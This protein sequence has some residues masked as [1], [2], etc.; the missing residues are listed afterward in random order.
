MVGD[1][2][3]EAW[4]WF[5]DCGHDLVGI[6]GASVTVLMGLRSGWWVLWWQRWRFHFFFQLW[7]WFDVVFSHGCGFG[8]GFL[9]MDGD[10]SWV[11]LG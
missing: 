10:G 11:W 6:G 4:W 5:G 7:F 2:G 8:D 9:A 3:H 1:C